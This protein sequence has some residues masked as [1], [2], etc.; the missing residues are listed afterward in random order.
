MLMQKLY[1]YLAQFQGRSGNMHRFFFG[2]RLTDSNSPV[3][4]HLIRWSNSKHI[5][6]HFTDQIIGSCEPDPVEAFMGT[7]PKD[8]ADWDLLTRAQWLELKLLAKM[9]SGT[10]ITENDHMALA[11]ILSTQILVDLFIVR[12]QSVQGDRDADR[13][14]GML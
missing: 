5:K 8:M 2:H 1:P 13:V 7:L 10:V 4:S 12:Q 11:G 3:Y 9:A 6:S 14:S